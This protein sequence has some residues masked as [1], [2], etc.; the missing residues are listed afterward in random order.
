MCVFETPRTQIW[1]VLKEVDRIILLH[2]HLQ[3]FL[4][5]AFTCSY[6]GLYW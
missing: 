6:C 1:N 2:I 5:P 3:S 4:L